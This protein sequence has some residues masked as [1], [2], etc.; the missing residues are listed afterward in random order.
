[1]LR[2]IDRDIPIVQ[3][4]DPDNWTVWNYIL[5]NLRNGGRFTFNSRNSKY[6]EFAAYM[7]DPRNGSCC[8]NRYIKKDVLMGYL[9]ETFYRVESEFGEYERT[10]LATYTA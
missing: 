9:M 4:E 10:V 1:M 2:K 3:P 5:P 7:E 8:A 6:I